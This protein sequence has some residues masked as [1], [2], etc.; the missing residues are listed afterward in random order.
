MGPYRRFPP[1]V[2]MFRQSVDSD[3]FLGFGACT[4]LAEFSNKPL[5]GQALTAKQMNNGVEPDWV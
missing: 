4:M 1:T 2:R 5:Q 3:A